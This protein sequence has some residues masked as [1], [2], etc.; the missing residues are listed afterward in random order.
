MTKKILWILREPHDDDPEGRLNIRHYL[1][2]FGHEGRIDR[3]WLYTWSSVA[4]VSYGILH[5]NEPFGDWCGN[6]TRY[7]PALLSIAAVNLKKT[8]GGATH[9]EKKLEEAFE[10]HSEA[11][12]R[13]VEDLAP[14]IVVCGNTFGLC[15]D[16]FEGAEDSWDDWAPSKAEFPSWKISKRVWVNAYHPAQR[17]VSHDK[18]YELIRQAIVRASEAT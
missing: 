3:N 12:R 18:Y 5:P 10:P 8:G 9:D 14:D 16:W 1:R 13:Q 11:I 4:K 17:T 6:A 15:R 7:V 2:E